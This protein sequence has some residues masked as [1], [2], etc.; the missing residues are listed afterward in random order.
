MESN[1]MLKLVPV[2]NARSRVAHYRT[3]IDAMDVLL[4]HKAFVVPKPGTP[5]IEPE[6]IEAPDITD[7]SRPASR[8]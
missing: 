4:V 6:D 2:L 3:G 5:A 8:F 1:M 7:L